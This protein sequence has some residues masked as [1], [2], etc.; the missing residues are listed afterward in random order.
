MFGGKLSNL[1]DIIR[2]RERERE[3]ERRNKE[4]RTIKS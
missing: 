2:R 1:L 3:C 4:Y